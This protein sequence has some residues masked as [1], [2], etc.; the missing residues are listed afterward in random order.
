MA[1]QR[2]RAKA[3]P[4][5]LCLVCREKKTRSELVRLVRSKDGQLRLDPAYRLPGRGYYVCLTADCIGPLLRGPRLAKQLQLAVDHPDLEAVRAGLN[6][7]L[8]EAE[9]LRSEA[10]QRAERLARAPVEVQD[11]AGRTVRRIRPE[12]ADDA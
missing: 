7:R 10:R 9:Q 5:R 11:E 6:A 8:E 2:P 3:K 4:E 1:K 12:A